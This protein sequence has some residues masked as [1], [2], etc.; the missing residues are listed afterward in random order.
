MSSKDGSSQSEEGQEVKNEES[1]EARS[2]IASRRLS[3]S[4]VRNVGGFE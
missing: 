3:F 1:L 4:P 2:G